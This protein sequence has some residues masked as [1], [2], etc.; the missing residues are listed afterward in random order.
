MNIAREIVRLKRELLKPNISTEEFR[1]IQVEIGRL[2]SLEM[3]VHSDLEPR[4]EVLE[5]SEKDLQNENEVFQD[6]FS[7][8]AEVVIP[9][10]EDLRG[11]KEVID[12]AVSHYE[13]RSGVI[14]NQRRADK[15]KEYKAELEEVLNPLLV[16]AEELMREEA[17]RAELEHVEPRTLYDLDSKL[18][19]R[20]EKLKKRI[21]GYE[22]R[23]QECL[24]N[25]H[26]V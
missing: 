18:S 15:L 20:I 4:I 13:T 22:K 10:E 8:K 5:P 17:E 24:K 7:T 26:W 6:D 1:R 23:I 16:R 9:G 2:K 3:E 14:N 19:E 25:P 21:A 11:E 12:S